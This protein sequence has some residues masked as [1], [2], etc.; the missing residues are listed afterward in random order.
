MMAGTCTIGLD[1]GT[2]SVRALLVE[3]GTGRELRPAYLGKLG[4]AYSSEWF[5]SKLPRCRRNSPELFVASRSWVEMGDW[6]PAVLCGETRP[7]LIKRGVCAA[8]HKAF[9]HPQWGGWP[10]ADFLRA[11]DP[12][13]Q[14]IASTFDRQALSIANEAGRLGLDEGIA[15]AVGAFDAHLGGVG[16]GIGPNILVKNIGTSTCDMMV[17]SLSAALPDIPGVAGV[18]PDSILP[19]YYGLE[20]GQAAVGESGLLALDWHNG[21]RTVLMDQ[22]LT[23]LIPGL[24]LL[25]S[26]AEIYRA[27]VEA[28]AFGARVIAERFEEY[29]CRIDRVVNCG[30]ISLK[31][32]MT[33]QI[34]ADVLG[35]TM[36][37][38]HS[39]A[40]STMPSASGARPPTSRP[41]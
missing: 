14:R 5:W 28:T 16:A 13:L 23:G 4:G 1:Y 39:I 22:R 38:S 40:S 24:T 27:M 15:V 30:G 36:E 41:R 17:S 6:V 8:G 33:M 7:E 12:E 34:Y 19:R 2:N 10:D 21:N 20:A 11:L 31:S 26:P 25:S 37:I 29:G 35:K 18:V 32:P 9:Y 3:V